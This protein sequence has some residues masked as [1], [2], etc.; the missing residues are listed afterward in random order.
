MGITYTVCNMSGH[1]KWSKIKHKKAATDA[2]KSKVFGKMAR[3]I[4][5]ESKKANGDITAPGLMTAIERAKA[6]SMPKDNINRAVAKG[7]SSD[8]AAMEEVV[9]ETYGPSGIAIIIDALTDNRNRTAAEMK[10]LLS[11]NGYEL[12]AQGSASWAFTKSADGY[13]PNSTVAINEED[14]EKLKKLLEQI[15][16]QD[17]VQ[18]MYT[19]A[20]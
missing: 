2:A 6:V 19:N 5:V 9:Y 8:A 7:S 1:N 14:G 20:Q 10:H 3:L 4:T 18:E 11:K 16:E 13:E 12:A 17:D 15:D